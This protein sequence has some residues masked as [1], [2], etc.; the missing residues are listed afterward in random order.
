MSHK[1]V[2]FEQEAREKV[3]RGANALADAVRVTLGPKSKCVLIERKFGKPLVCNDGVTIAKEVDLEDAVENLGAQVL[4]EAAERTGEAVGDG[5]TTATL[6]AH[7][8]LSEGIKNLA[9]GASAIDLKRG[10]ERGLGVATKTIRALSRPV[11]TKRAKAHVATISAHNDAAI[12]ELVADA[13]D[14]V[15]AEG[16]VTVEEAKG[17][18]TSVEVVEGM[19]F[20]RGFLSPYFVTD[21]EKVETVLDE[22]FLLLHEKRISTMHDLLPL[23]EL[24]AK[25]GRPL[26]VVAE[27]VDGEALATLVVNKLRGTLAC[28]AVKAP[29]FGDRRKAML[30]DMAILT[31]ARAITEEIGMKLENLTLEQLG[32]AKRVIVD[33]ETTTIVGGLGDRAAIDGRCKELRKQI[34]DATSDYDKEKL[35][36]RLARLT[37]GVAV[38]HVGAASETELKSRKEAIEDAINATRAAVSEGMV[39]GAGLALLR[40]IADVDT[41][42]AKCAGDERTGVLILERA[43]EAP[44]RQIAV[45]SGVDAGVVVDRM[46]S[47]QGAAGFD[48]ATGKYVDLVEAGI[49]DPTKVVRVGLENAVSVASVLLLTEATL[50]EIPET[51]KNGQRRPQPELV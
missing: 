38:V 28:V 6:L 22:P 51:D 47:S 39:P 48:A 40:A 45:N 1:R 5:T 50:T 30:E 2:F 14:K 33:R 42:A 7:A 34:D 49:V 17:T 20:D 23:L 31:G 43:L 37:G 32:K 21:A 46:R 13:I 10:L 25:A 9:A 11:E 19:Q 16:V 36:E 29:G 3:Q 44:T 12:G 18:E 24:V 8:I 35:Q 26:M 15:G 4:R 41:E 27:D